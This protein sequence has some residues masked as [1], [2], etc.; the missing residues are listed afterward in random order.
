MEVNGKSTLGP[1]KIQ[2]QNGTNM[3]NSRAF[4]PHI[5]NNPS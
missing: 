5:A 1:K 3:Q 4:M 2:G